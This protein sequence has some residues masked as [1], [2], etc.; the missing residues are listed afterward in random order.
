M[1]R[2]SIWKVAQ[3]SRISLRLICVVQIS[4]YGKHESVNRRDGAGAARFRRHGSG[5]KVQEAGSG[6]AGPVSVRVLG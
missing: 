2:V 5:D 6:G 4:R 1:G 3:P